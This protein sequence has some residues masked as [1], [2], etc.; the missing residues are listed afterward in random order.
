[1]AASCFVAGF[2]T[3]DDLP[4]HAGAGGSDAG[5]GGGGGAA[6]C[7]HASYPDPPA[8]SDPGVNDVQFVLAA[9]SLDFGETDDAAGP[10]IGYDLDDRCTCQGE[11]S[12][13]IEPDWATEDNCDG[14]QGRDN[15]WAKLFH[16]A[17]LFDASLSSAN[18]AAQVDAGDFTM[19]VRVWDYNGEPN[20]DQVTVAI[21]ASP[22][23]GKDPCNGPS[24]LP[25][26]VGHDR[27]PVMHTALNGT[28]GAGGGWPT[29][30]CGGGHGVPPGYDLDDPRWLD[31]N[32]YVNQGVMVAS[33][34][35]SE[36]LLSGDDSSAK[37]KLTVAFM[38][39]TLE[40]NPSTLQWE[41]RD[42]L[43]AGRWEINALLAT[44]GSLVTGAG[45]ALCTDHLL[46]QPIKTAVCSFPD[47][48]AGISGPTAPCNAISFGMA[49]E[50]YE[51]EL[52][53]VFFPTQQ[54]PT[55]PPETDP[56]NDECG[57]G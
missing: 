2:E 12:N 43:L 18:F 48:T 20:D 46:Y 10:Q 55:C 35:N 26:W 47:V 37:V 15:A 28:G 39:G 13:C 31:V 34:P 5:G 40:L 44:L 9:R 51:A 14:P 41:I 50:A 23:F 22:G 17:S 30:G 33:L 57:S 42:G 49:F 45:E 54:P 38:T 36:I 52:G 56:A 4:Q 8:Q 32:A 6:G 1:M 16:S 24:A 21:Y 7:Q 53:V 11:G 19:L 29:G 25:S 27:W 3:V